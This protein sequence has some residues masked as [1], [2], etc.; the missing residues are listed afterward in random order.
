M[1]ELGFYGIITERG[2]VHMVSPWQEN[3]NVLEFV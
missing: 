1:Y 2:Q 3:G